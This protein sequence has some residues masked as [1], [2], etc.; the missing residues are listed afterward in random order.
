MWL[1]TFWYLHDAQK[2]PRVW[3]IE[4]VD[5]HIRKATY[6]TVAARLESNIAV[7]NGDDHHVNTIPEGSLDGMYIF[8]TSVRSHISAARIRPSATDMR[9]S[10]ALMKAKS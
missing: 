10:C 1:W 4:I 7:R 9:I 3:Y 5:G 8:E 6:S 2:G